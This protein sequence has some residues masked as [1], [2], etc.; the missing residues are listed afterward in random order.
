MASFSFW[1]EYKKV[2]KSSYWNQDQQVQIT[3][4]ILEELAEE[5][6]PL[7]TLFTECC[8]VTDSWKKAD[9]VL[10]HNK[11]K[12]DELHNYKQIS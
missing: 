4:L 12:V 10:T 3:S 7:R 6:S 1:Q 9:F 11:N 2:S 8:K 5:L